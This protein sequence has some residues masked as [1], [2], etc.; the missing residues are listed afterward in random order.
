M[1]FR[2]TIQMEGVLYAVGY[3]RSDPSRYPVIKYTYLR[4]PSLKFLA[5]RA[6]F[7]DA[8]DEF[9]KFWLPW[10]RPSN[11]V[12]FLRELCPERVARFTPPSVFAGEE[13]RE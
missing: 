2:I 6:L 12:P 13:E 9:C 4:P 7:S 8:S 11:I 5:L 3:N 10:A 1:K